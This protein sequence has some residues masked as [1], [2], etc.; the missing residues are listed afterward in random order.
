MARLPRNLQVVPGYPV[1]LIQRG[2]NRESCFFDERDRHLFLDLLREYSGVHQ[3]ALHAFV[4]MSNHFHL[5]LTPATADAVSRMMRSVNQRYVQN[6]NKRRSRSGSLWDGRFHT[7]L[8]DDDPYFISCQRYI[9]LNPV[10][11]GMV[12]HPCGYRWSSCRANANGSPSGFLQPH[13]TYLALGSTAQARTEAYR[14]LVEQPLEDEVLAR[15]RAGRTSS[16]RPC[17][18]PDV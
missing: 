8:V 4:L 7:F 13:P 10:R 15:I 5:L 2:H 16:L 17:S 12:E 9:E 6:V 1:H 14:K 11:A 3:C 18:V